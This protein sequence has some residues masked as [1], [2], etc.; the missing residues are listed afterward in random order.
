LADGPRRRMLEARLADLLADAGL[1]RAAAPVADACIDRMAD[2][3]VAALGAFVAAGLVRTLSGRCRDTL[4]LCDLAFP[5]ALRHLDEVPAGVGWI[6]M[7]RMLALYTDGDLVA[8][9]EIVAAVDSMVVD[10]PD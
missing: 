8:T 6:A 4:Q 10:D 1:L 2:D 7:Q 3:E 5:V 9:T